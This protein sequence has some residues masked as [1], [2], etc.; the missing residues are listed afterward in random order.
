MYFTLPVIKDYQRKLYLI[1]ALLLAGCIIVSMLFYRDLHP[2]RA[3]EQRPRMLYKT[4]NNVTKKKPSPRYSV[5]VIFKQRLGNNMFQYAS[6]FGIA[7]SKSMSLTISKKGEFQKI[8]KVSALF[9]SDSFIETH[10]VKRHEKHASAY[11]EDLVDFANNN[12]YALMMYLQSWKYFI[13]EEKALRKEFTFTEKVQIKRDKVISTILRKHN[14]TS[15]NDVTFIG[16]HIR[17]SDRPQPNRRSQRTFATAAYLNQSVHHFLS[18]HLTNTIFLVCSSRIDWSR[19]NM[20]KNIAVEYITG[21][22]AA[23]DLAILGSCDHM[24]STTGTFGWW[25]GWLTGGEVVYFKWPARE[26]TEYRQVFDANYTDFFY[27]GWVG[28]Q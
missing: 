4:T 27:P 20:P 21:N 19:R 1:L 26:G 10:C 11:D 22:S 17:R 3:S 25:A 8:F 14:H 16:I 23:V 15:Q 18:K 28:F 7:A 5:C 13:K 6:S 24:I 12:N 9:R 2:S